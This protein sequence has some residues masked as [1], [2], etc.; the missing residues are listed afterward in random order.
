MAKGSGSEKSLQQ[1]TA[2]IASKGTG[3]EVYTKLISENP[4][5]YR[6]VGITTGRILR[7]E[8]P[9]SLPVQQAV[10]FEMVINQRTAAALGLTIPP[11]LLARADEV[12]E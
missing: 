2:Q 9:A 12:I 4:R 8:I 5:T 6:Q 1:R 11:T 7:G 3:R 10:K